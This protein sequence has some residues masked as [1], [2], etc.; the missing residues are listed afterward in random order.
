[1]SGEG[2]REYKR[3][4]HVMFTHSGYVDFVHSVLSVCGSLT[5]YTALVLLSPTPSGLSP[6]GLHN[7]TGPTK[8]TK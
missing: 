5:A 6:K 1:M 4:D 8:S 2:G 3:L 7:R